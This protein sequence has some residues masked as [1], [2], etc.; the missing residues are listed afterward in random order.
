MKGGE[1]FCSHCLKLAILIEE[2]LDVDSDGVCL[3]LI[4][5]KKRCLLISFITSAYIIHNMHT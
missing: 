3:F 2:K 1:G 5:F 4:N